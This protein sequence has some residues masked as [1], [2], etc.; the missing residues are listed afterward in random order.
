[1][2]KIVTRAQKKESYDRKFCELLERFDKAFIVHA[3]NVGSKQFQNIRAALREQG[4]TVIL[5][6]KNTMMK[7]CLRLYIDRTGNDKWS[8]LLEILVG[9]VGIV[10]TAMSLTD[11]RD[12]IDEFRVGAPARAGVIAP[13]SV[14]VSAGPT[15]MDPK[16]TGFFQALNIQ[17]KIVKAQIEIVNAVTVIEEGD[18][19]N[20]TQA[21]LLDKLKIMPFEYKMNI[22]SFLEGGKLVDAKVLAITAEDIMES[23]SAAA[24]NITKLSLGSGYIVSSATPH[25]LINAFKNLAGAAITA[26]YDFPAL[27]ALKSAAA[28]APRAGGAAAAGAPA[29]AEAAPEPEE[30]VDM[31]D[32][33]GGGD[34]DY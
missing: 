33:F 20:P 24:L 34:D 25:L 7:R 15:G 19:V 21:A 30:D 13:C 29:A 26:D 8:G 14:G 31:G 28:A 22:R 1:M 11:V 23:F 27:A 12:K 4:D 3:D 6:G 17:T 2:P 16:Q 32:L 18:K 10:F 5:M 9:N